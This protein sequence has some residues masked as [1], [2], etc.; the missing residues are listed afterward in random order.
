M[1]GVFKS[2]VPT[3][4]KGDFS[5]HNLWKDQDRK[6]HFK[7]YKSG[8]HWVFAGLA[9][10]GLGMG[11]GISGGNVLADTHVDGSVPQTDHEDT[12]QMI[13]TDKQPGEP[14]GTRVRLK[15]T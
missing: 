2:Y 7:M 8:K 4:L 1:N 5:M 14:D 12:A 6:V 9:V 3:T 11:L 13:I 10:V 15:T